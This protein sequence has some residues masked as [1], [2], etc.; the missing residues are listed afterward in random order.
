MCEYK[1][2]ELPERKACID[3]TH[4]CTS[5]LPKYAAVSIIGYLK[6]KSSMI[7]FKKYSKL[8][9]NFKEH[10]SNPLKGCQ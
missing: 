8:K 6:G 9:R 7:V 10:S 2:I 4:V 1:G 3:H 5:T